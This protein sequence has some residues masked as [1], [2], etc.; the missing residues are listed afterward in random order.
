MKTDRGTLWIHL[1]LLLLAAALVLTAYNTMASHE[2]GET[3]RQVIEQLCQAL[4]TESTAATEAPSVPEYLLDAAR[5]MPVKTIDGED[6]IG[7]LT[8]PALELEL[9]VISQWDYAALKAAPCRYSGSLYQN[10]LIICA[11]NYSSHF[12][13]LKN[14][15]VG[16][17]A[18][19]TDMEENAVTFRMVERETL[20][21]TDLEGM[22]AGDW[23]MTLY[24]CTV[25][26]QSRVTVRFLREA[27]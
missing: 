23:D 15:R 27:P 14:L 10:D 20:E 3:S 6:Y 7:V 1:G 25:G 4:H 19:F 26:G 16:D 21:P 12:G 13:R 18:I 24:T 22:E 9:P 5:E 8:I 17:I 11:H 2:A